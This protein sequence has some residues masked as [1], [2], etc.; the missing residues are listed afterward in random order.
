MKTR[1][2]TGSIL[3]L[4]CCALFVL[5]IPFPAL[6]DEAPLEE[7]P[8]DAQGP[9]P[10]QVTVSGTAA[11]SSDE[12]VAAGGAILTTPEATPFTGTL[13]YRIPIELPPGRKGLA[14][15]LALAYNSGRKNGWVGVGWTLDPGCIQRASKWGVDYSA[16]DFVASVHG[17]ITELVPRSDW[18]PTY[19]G[20]RIEGA[21]TKYSYD[22]SR[23]G[24]VVTAKNG[25]RYYYGYHSDRSSQQ[26]DP[27]TGTFRWLLDE[28]EDTNGN[29]IAFFYRQDRGAAY[30]LR[31]EYTGNKGQKPA[32]QVDFTLEERPD[33]EISYA[34]GQ[35]VMTALRLKT[36]AVTAINPSGQE[37]KVT[38]YILAYA[39]SQST[40]RSVLGSV[41]RHGSSTGTA[42]DCEPASP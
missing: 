16:R 29:T 1:Q 19:H 11:T 14:P 7:A 26:G 32:Y 10:G 35:R 13:S 39:A 5:S 27:A 36:V 28:V 25:T 20:S 30:P 41:T 40:N 2:L 15:D 8:A 23:D 18:G 4:S 33:A 12:P 37:V 34:M 9:P 31:I 6:S 42:W 22:A 24:W 38:R 21:F 3:L 17:V